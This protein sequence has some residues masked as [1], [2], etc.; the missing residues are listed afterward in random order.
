MVFNSERVILS[1]AVNSPV[2]ECNG[3]MSKYEIENEIVCQDTY[4]ELQAKRCYGHIM[5]LERFIMA[6]CELLG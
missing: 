5:E 6:E 2:L 3:R 4:S 1:L